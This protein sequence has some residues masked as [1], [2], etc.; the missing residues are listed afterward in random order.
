M[1]LS[2]NNDYSKGTINDFVMNGL[3]AKEAKALAAIEKELSEL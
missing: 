3:L 1:I 2:V